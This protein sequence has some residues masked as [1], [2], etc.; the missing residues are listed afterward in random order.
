MHNS[1]LVLLHHIGVCVFGRIFRVI[2]AIALLFVPAT[3]SAAVLTDAKLDWAKG[4][5]RL[6]LKFDDEVKYTYFTLENPDRLVIDVADARWQADIA[7]DEAESGVVAG[8]RHGYFKPDE[9][10][11]VADLRQPVKV[12]INAEKDKAGAFSIIAE[13]HE[14]NANSKNEAPIPAPVKIALPDQKP[15]KSAYPL[16]QDKPSPPDKNRKPVIII[17]PGHGG[18]DSGALGRHD[19]VMEKD[20]TLRYAKKL[21]DALMGTG[22]YE[23]YLTRTEDEFLKLRERIEIARKKDGDIFISLHAD[24]HP[25]RGT[26]GFSVYTL[27]ESASDKEAEMLAQRENRADVLS[28]VNLNGQSPEVAGMLIELAQRDTMNK[29]AELARALVAELTYEEIMS[30]RNTHR[31]AGFAVLKSPDIPSILLEM[32]FLS[33][34]QDERQLRS[35]EFENRLTASVVAG[36]E[37]YFK[38][39]NR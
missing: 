34:A 39:K 6:M 33:N 27:S 22:H 26:R 15:A 12:K 17:D 3:A 24:S 25:D 38:D 31:S 8:V 7:A 4:V 18:H 5:I 21:R 9:L 1:Y 29:S 14:I 35:K 13:L 36:V 2:A 10:R 28:S 32:G 19:N 23:V 11:V 16:P 30:V 20:I 37:R